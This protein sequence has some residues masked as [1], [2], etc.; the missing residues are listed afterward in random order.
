MTFEAQTGYDKQLILNICLKKSWCHKLYISLAIHYRSQNTCHI[1]L[2]IYISTFWYQEMAF[3]TYTFMSNT[4][5][6][7]YCSTQSINNDKWLYYK[8]MT[9]NNCLNDRY[10]VNAFFLSFFYWKNKILQWMAGDKY[11][12]VSVSMWYIYNIGFLFVQSFHIY[13]LRD[14]FMFIY[15]DFIYQV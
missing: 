11:V 1:F 14:V 15:F 8:K 7:N 12:I 6:F 3:K 9:N 10:L 4:G 13:L 5:H 2:Y